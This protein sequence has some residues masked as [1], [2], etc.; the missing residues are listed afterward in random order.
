MKTKFLAIIAASLSAV[1]SIVIGAPA[2]AVEQEVN[3]EITI[4]PTMFLRTFENISLDITQGDLGANDKDFDPTNN[5][6]D[7]NT[8]LT[9]APRPSLADGNQL[10][11]VP[12]QVKELYAVWANSGTNV[13]VTIEATQDTLTSTTDTAST[14]TITS[15]TPTQ[16]NGSPTATT[17]LVGGADFVFD[18]TNARATGTYSGGMVRVKAEAQL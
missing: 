11:A 17:P 2:N 14:A 18:L 16:P 13:D 9:V 10:S 7:G 12:K 6:T 3:V 1:G 5:T 15:V 4:Q 8:N